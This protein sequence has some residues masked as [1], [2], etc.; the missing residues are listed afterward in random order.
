MNLPNID[1][2]PFPNSVFYLTGLSLLTL[3][4]A[5]YSKTI[6]KLPQTVS[7]GIITASSNINEV[8]KSI[9]MGTKDLYGKMTSPFG[10]GSGPAPGP[11]IAPLTNTQPGPSDN[12]L[13]NMNPFAQTRPTEAVPRP[14]EAVPRPTETVPRPAEAVPRPPVAGGSKKKRAKR[15][16]KTKRSRR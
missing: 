16:K 12:I 4:Y 14:A 13:E 5:T 6:N 2:M 11:I 7:D 8:G 10:A 15:N 9:S 3:V 1:I